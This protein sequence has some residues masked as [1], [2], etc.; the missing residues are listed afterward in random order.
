MTRFLICLV[1]YFFAIGMGVMVMIF[2]WG[3][4]PVSWGWIV[5]GQVAAALV[6]AMFQLAD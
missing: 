4:E 5:G 3:M 2:E 1:G 6:G